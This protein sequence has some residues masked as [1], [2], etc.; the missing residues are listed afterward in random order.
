MPT[1]HIKE[2]VKKCIS[3]LPPDV[4]LVAAAKTRTP[5]ELKA[6]VEAGVRIFGYNYLQEAE[7]MF[8]HIGHSV[9][10]HMIGHLQSNKAKRAALLFDMIE[11]IDS[12]KIARQVNRFCADMNK[13]MPV[14]IEINSGEESNKTGV[15]P[16]DVDD[17]VREIS[18]LS[19]L[20]IQGLMTMGPRFGDPEDA[21]PYFRAT[22]A[23]FGR[24]SKANIANV[25]M[26][27]LS[28]GM[29]NSYKIAI[30]EGAN[31]VRIGTYLF[32]GRQ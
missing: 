9:Q 23:A 18:T 19:H 26:R 30:K 3:S 7:Q 24:L 14:L 15:L 28:M 32:G 25:E 20:R 17:L 22:K 2:T 12:L 31:I 11:T 6:A 29:S 16:G 27:F 8:P 21:R 4:D 1:T 5:E 10:W 13:I